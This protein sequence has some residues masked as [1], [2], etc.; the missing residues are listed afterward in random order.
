MKL[1]IPLICMT[2]WAGLS[3]GA[4]AVAFERGRTNLA[5]ACCLAGVVGIGIL[6]C[7]FAMAVAP[8]DPRDTYPE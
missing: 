1:G 3:I 6:G 7:A 5:F 2:A 8:R 4:F